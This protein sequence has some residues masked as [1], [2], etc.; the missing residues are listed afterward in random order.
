MENSFQKLNK[1]EQIKMAETLA[2]AFSNHDNFVYLIED[3]KKRL[4]AASLLFQFMTKVMNKY[5]YIYVVYQEEEP[6]GY[7]TFMDDQK[8]KLDVTTVLKSNAL[9]KTARFWFFISQSERKKY[10][11][12][13]KTYNEPVHKEENLIHLYYTGVKEAY[14]GKGLM[15][16]AMSDALSYFHNLGYKGVC[17]ETSDQN[18]VGLYKHLG[19]EVTR[20]VKTKDERQ[21]IFFFE[22]HF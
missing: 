13:L 21:E 2:D 5:G 1:W 3:D 6:V 19:Y 8:N 7:I 16:Q 10:L 14:R 22:K 15:K 4:K 11:S 17:L 20:R 12:Y 9:W 18:N